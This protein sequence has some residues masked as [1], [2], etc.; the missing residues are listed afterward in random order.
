MNKSLCCQLLFV[1][2][3]VTR[4][5]GCK[6]RAFLPLHNSFES[7]THCSGFWW[8]IHAVIQRQKK[9][10]KHIGSLLGWDTGAVTFL[11]FAGNGRCRDV[12]LQMKA[13]GE[14]LCSS[15]HRRVKLDIRRCVAVAPPASADLIKAQTGAIWR[16][17]LK[18]KSF[19]SV[20]FS[21]RS[22]CLPFRLHV[23]W[24]LN[25]PSLNSLIS[26]CFF[27]FTSFPRSLWWD[28]GIQQQGF[29]LMTLHR[30]EALLIKQRHCRIPL[31]DRSMKFLIYTQRLLYCPWSQGV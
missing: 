2:W 4:P 3:G 11:R 26:C 14:M 25:S 9:K 13:P 7:D 27:F 20:P 30:L 10:Q 24:V 12:M 1:R 19:S 17:D 16:K 5:P 6:T 8:H 22:Y 28:E 29:V 21:P 23:S 15:L 18:I 31:K